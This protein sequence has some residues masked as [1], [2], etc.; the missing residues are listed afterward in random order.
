M[1]NMPE[2]P[3]WMTDAYNVADPVPTMFHYSAGPHGIAAVKAFSDGRTQSGWGLKDSETGKPSFIPL[4]ARKRFDIRRAL[5]SYENSGQAFAFVMRSMQLICID[6]DGKNGGFENVGKLGL[7]PPTLAE[8]SKSGNGYHLFYY[9]EER[10]SPTEG[11]GEYKDFIGVE[12]GVD[13]RATGC[14]YHYNTQRWNNREIAVLPAWISQKLIERQNKITAKSDYI[15]KLISGNQTD[16]VLVMQTQLLDELAKPIDPGKR[17]N[18]LFAIG[19]QMF[20][21]QIED[22][23]QRV[24]DRAIDV[25]LDAN[26]A[27]K[28]VE[29]IAKYGA[30]AP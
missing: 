6:I 16:E 22:W 9:T 3:W 21:A 2:N 26:E 20:Q 1:V 18:T 27:S 23:D 30:T 8:T 7:L 15:I 17:N 11:Y 13:I 14:V 25:G 5:H 10:W 19:S 29:N 24:Y 28:L 12:Q 4:Y